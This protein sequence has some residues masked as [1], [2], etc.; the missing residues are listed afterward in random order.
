MTVGKLLGNQS[1]IV[2]LIEHLA[3]DGN[4]GFAGRRQFGQVFAAAAED[5]I[6]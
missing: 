6:L 3:R 2:D 1:D 4:D 5:P